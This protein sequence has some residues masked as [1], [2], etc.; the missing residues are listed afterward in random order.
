MP[1]LQHQYF[2]N[3]IF[4]CILTI[5]FLH[6]TITKRFCSKISNIIA[7]RKNI[8]NTNVKIE[9]KICNKI[10]YVK[11]KIL[12]EKK[13]HAQDIIQLQQNYDNEK[14]LLLEILRKNNISSIEKKKYQ[15]NSKLL[16][17]NKKWQPRSLK[18]MLL[19]LS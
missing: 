5:F 15:Y 8:I 4:W 1:H 18:N 19:G 7:K 6:N 3:M 2:F 14:K 13:Q 17:L 12:E 16:F 9:L 10:H 11:E